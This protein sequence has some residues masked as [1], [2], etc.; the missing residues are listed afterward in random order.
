MSVT[1]RIT[2]LVD[3][4]VK[5]AAFC[6]PTEHVL[7]IEYILKITLKY[8]YLYIKLTSICITLITSTVSDTFLFLCRLLRNICP[9][10]KPNVCKYSNYFTR[11]LNTK[12]NNV[13]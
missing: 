4:Q 11:R 1:Q 2:L 3:N 6:K 9:H 5:T 7:S 10:F 13:E 12:K 8:K